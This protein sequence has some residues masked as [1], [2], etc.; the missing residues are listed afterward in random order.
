MKL[1]RRAP[2]TQLPA[3]LRRTGVVAHHDVPGRLHRR[4]NDAVD[5]VFGYQRP[6]VTDQIIAITGALLVGRRSYQVGRRENQVG[7]ATKPYLGTWSGPQFVLTHQSTT[8][9]KTRPSPSSEGHRGR[10]R[11]RPDGGRRKERGGDRRSG[12]RQCLAA[13]LIDEILIH[14]APILLGA[15]TRLY[16]GSGPAPVDA[17]DRQRF[18]VG[19]A[20]RP[21][22]PGRAFERREQRRADSGGAPVARRAEGTATRTGS[23][24]R[25]RFRLALIRI[26]TAPKPR[27]AVNPPVITFVMTMPALTVACSITHCETMSI[28]R[29]R[30]WPSSGGTSVLASSSARGQDGDRDHQNQV[31]H[32]T[33][34]VVNRN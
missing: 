14:V 8:R 22:V 23:H 6:P 2:L 1:T 16:E 32:R 20:G 33:F 18:A 12:R 24:H 25:P 4:P 29:S 13:G 19:T 5:W 30:R 26:D 28:A 10:R 7:A 3:A 11:H 27:I 31:V 21:V 17:A 15:G 34:G 9:R